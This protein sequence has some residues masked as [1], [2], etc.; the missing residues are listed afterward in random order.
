M[1][2]SYVRFSLPDRPKV[3][4]KSDVHKIIEVVEEF[5]KRGQKMEDDL[6]R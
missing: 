2:Y 1:V 5:T 4:G 3:P 6:L